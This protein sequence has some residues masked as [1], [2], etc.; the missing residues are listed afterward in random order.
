MKQFFLLLFLLTFFFLYKNKPHLS[1]LSAPISPSAV[2]NSS[3]PTPTV[4]Q[5]IE[6][7]NP[8]KVKPADSY[9]ILFVGDSMTASLGENFDEL[10][11]ALANTYPNKVFGLFNYGFG[12]TNIFSVEDRLTKESNYLG[13]TIPAALDRY[14]D[15]IIIESFGYN[16][17]SQYPRGVGL[18]HQTETLARAL[19]MI[20][21]AK[22]ESLIILMSTIAPSKRLY[23]VGT[24]SFSSEERTKQAEERMAYLENHI[25]YA[26]KH[27]FPL[28][29]VYEKSKDK[30]GNALLK[31]INSNDH[32]HPS[33]EG[34]KFISEQIA[35]YFKQNEVLPK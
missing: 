35:E 33:A 27:N 31:Y 11:K 13:K 18:T 6:I 19:S 32:I 21:K 26:Q 2:L 14:F 23:A 34:V 8:P 12:A 3:S 30:E 16:P 9:T 24:V 29:N 28:I 5:P 1:P 15:I 7:Y 10:R 4:Y 25:A 20:N 17:L 22:P